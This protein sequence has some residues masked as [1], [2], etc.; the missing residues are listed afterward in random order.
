MGGLMASVLL[1]GDG[2]GFMMFLVIG[3][4]VVGLI[5]WSV[6]HQKKVREN[7]LMFA[8]KNGLQVQGATNR[9]IIQGWLGQVYVTLNTVIRGSGKNRSTY[10]QYHVGIN[11]PMPQGLSLTKEGF[12]SKVGKVFGGQDVQIGDRAIDDAFI[13]KAG[14]MLGAHNLLSLP[15]VKKALL[16]TIA[17]HPGLRVS[18]RNILVE[19]NGMTGDLRK[20][21]GVFEDLTY[22]AL[23]LDAGYQ[24]LAGGRAMPQ[25]AQQAR[26]APAPRKSS[27][28]RSAPAEI[29]AQSTYVMGNAATTRQASADE[30]PARRAFQPQPVTEK[31]NEALSSMA[32]ALDQYAKKLES[33]E[34]TPQRPAP[35]KLEDAFASQDNNAA[36]E[37]AKLNDDVESFDQSGA[38]ALSDYNPGDAFNS[39][40]TEQDTGQSGFSA[41]DDPDG[42][43]AFKNPE[44][45]E[46]TEPAKPAEV[47][48]TDSDDNTDKET[49]LAAIIE[50]LSDRSLMSR[51]R[52]EIIKR[53]L[54]TSW[55][56][57]LKVDRLEN[58][59]GFDTPDNLRDG[60]TV[61][62]VGS[63][64]NKY[65][66]RF[67]KARNDDIG[68]LRSGDTLKTWGTLAAWD[69]L[70]K[71]ITLDAQ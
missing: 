62:A 48:A 13:I 39:A 50:K 40:P 36:F 26:P 2:F 41:F 33:G 71:K 54:G 8:R 58:T 25:G 30:I 31:H 55:E 69:D 23:T 14:D 3:A 24:E 70:F 61:E 20:I 65:V 34:A 53:H 6:I 45:F 43:D 51:D 42:G 29:L 15:P 49:S 19:H 10:T 57:E 28:S 46:T 9:P 68:K 18:D 16:Y 59:W 60:K 1:A 37:N 47:T 66:V 4:G 67:P 22:L 17:R 35:P 7:W 52:E 11:A 21:E 64:G 27:S 38:A 44:P 63:D 56:V 32:S 5:I 12:F